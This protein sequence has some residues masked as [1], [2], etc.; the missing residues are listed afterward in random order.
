MWDLKVA[1]HAHGAEGIE[2]VRFVMKGGVVY[3]GSW[4]YAWPSAGVSS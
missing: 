4:L 3:K 2:R 1:A